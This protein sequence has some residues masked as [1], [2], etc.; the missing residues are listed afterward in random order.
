M[1]E[2][3]FVFTIQ[4]GLSGLECLP[5]HIKGPQNRWMMIP[6]VGIFHRAFTWCTEWS[7]V[8]YLYL[9]K[10]K[11][12]KNKSLLDHMLLL[13][14]RNMHLKDLFNLKPAFQH[15]RSMCRLIK[16]CSI[17]FS[18]QVHQRTHFSSSNDAEPKVLLW[19]TLIFTWSLQEDS[20]LMNC[21]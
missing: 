21:K 12:I 16:L 2:N 10:P 15:Q 20:D 8:Y 5:L 19:S 9:V 6:R 13:K 1:H 7:C 11:H 17:D 3:L 4:I 14:G 18:S